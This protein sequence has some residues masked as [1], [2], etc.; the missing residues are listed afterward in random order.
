MYIT[1]EEYNKMYDPVEEKLFERLAFE[2]CRVMDIHTSGVDGV[3]KLQLFFPNEEYDV[4]AVKHC[5]AKVVNTLLQLHNAEEAASAGRGYVETEQGLQR[6]VISRIEAGNE[7]ISFSDAKNTETAIDAASAD[8]S[9]REKL[10]RS[11]VVDGLRGVDDANGVSL[12][13]MGAYPR[14]FLC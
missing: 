6:R 1:S 9:A 14:R 7:A 2:A 4:A 13:Y 8:V 3:K 5:A 10:L 11:V 12:L